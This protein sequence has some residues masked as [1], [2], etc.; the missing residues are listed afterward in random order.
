MIKG[1]KVT[2][3]LPAAGIGKRMGAGSKKQF[4]E[5]HGKPILA[6]T[7]EKFHHAIYVD[8]VI[9]VLQ[10]EWIPFVQEEII[11]PYGFSRVHTLVPGGA[12]RQDSVYE[13]LKAVK[14]SDI[15]LV[16]DAVRP[17]VRADK[18]DELIEIAVEYP[19]AILAVRPKDTIKQQDAN[20][21]VA[22]T[23]D[24]N[25]LWNVQTPQAFQYSLLRSAFDKAYAE[26]YYGTDEAMLIE[27]LGHAVKIVE[28]HYDNI[29]ITTPED[30]ALAER[31]LKH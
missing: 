8:E 29:K 6:H 11:G 15:V 4:L 21:F 7:L 17:C 9:L 31:F 5:V 10:N 27:R 1:K 24:R 20:G 19:A 28:G 30:L 3:I 14:E 22:R 13:G 12:E 25:T 23:I 18:I 26:K 2:A 16:H